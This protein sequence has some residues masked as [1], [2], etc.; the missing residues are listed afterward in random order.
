ML[1]SLACVSS[2]YADHG[3]DNEIIPNPELAIVAASTT[4]MRDGFAH[5]VINREDIKKS[6]V[7]GFK[8]LRNRGGRS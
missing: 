1:L 4:E 6:E 3:P 7:G 8:Q 5:A 2:T